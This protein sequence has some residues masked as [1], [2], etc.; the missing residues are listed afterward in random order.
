MRLRIATT[1][2][3]IAC[4]VAVANAQTNAARAG[5]SSAGDDAEIS[6]TY[7]FLQD[8]EFVQIDVQQGKVGGFISRYEDGANDLFLD[9]FIKQGTRSGRDLAFETQPVHGRWYSFKGQVERGAAKTR[10]EEGFWVMR[11]RLTVFDSDAAKKVTS[12]E[13]EVTLKLFPED[14]EPAEKRPEKH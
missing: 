6:G 11:G 3:L 4:A 2:V 10:T 1:A 12:R 13:R 7:T 8:G 9:H 5:N 14:A